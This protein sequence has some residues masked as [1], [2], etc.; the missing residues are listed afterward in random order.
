L[1][2]CLLWLEVDVDVEGGKTE[3]GRA[4]AVERVKPLESGRDDKGLHREWCL[5]GLACSIRVKERAG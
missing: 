1:F 2:V 5:S 4:G 3:L